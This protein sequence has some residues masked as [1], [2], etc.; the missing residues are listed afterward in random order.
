MRIEKLEHIVNNPQDNIDNDNYVSII[1]VEQ[2]LKQKR[3]EL[4][5]KVDAYKKHLYELLGDNYDIK[6][7][8]YDNYS[9]YSRIVI[10]PDKSMLSV[11][12]SYTLDYH[13]DVYARNKNHIAMS[14]SLIKNKLQKDQITKDFNKEVRE[15]EEKYYKLYCG[16]KTDNGLF[17]DIKQDTDDL[18]IL[19]SDSNHD[20]EYAR[21]HQYSSCKR[22]LPGY[23]LYHSS[24][25]NY[26]YDEKGLDHN[27]YEPHELKTEEDIINFYYLKDI[28]ANTRKVVY[29][30]DETKEFLNETAIANAYNGLKVDISS[31]SKELQEEIKYFENYHRLK[32]EESKDQET[33]RLQKLQAERLMEAY[34]K[35]KEAA[36]MLVNLQMDVKLE[37]IKLDNLESIFFKNN[38]QPD[39]LGAKVIDDMFKNNMLLRM[40]DLSTID[41]TDVDIRNMDFSGTN[42]HIDPQTVYN[43]DMTNVNATGLKFSPFTDKFDD[44]ILDGTIIDDLEAMIDFEKVKSYN[45]Q[46]MINNS[47]GRAR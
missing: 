42:I 2:V 16:L 5:N 46:T 7:E 1:A 15:W 40:L 10:V 34:K 14:V 13:G 3:N 25:E 27:N 38:G 29:V 33:A 31:F 28:G 9:S 22:V 41:L 47:T 26:G 21:S 30:T 39:A 6:F 4:L 43:K 17:I 45:N 11:V 8:K 36:E 20:S 12:K 37:K 32:L 19:L 18:K 35:F 23:F 24:K 44:T